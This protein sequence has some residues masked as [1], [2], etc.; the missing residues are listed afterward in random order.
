MAGI[1]RAALRDAIAYARGRTRTFLV[2]G[3][4]KPAEDPLV[5][6]VIG[7]LS[8][9]VFTLEGIVTGVS[10]VLDDAYA[11][12]ASGKPGE[13]AYLRADMA[14]YNGQ[15][16][17]IDLVL[18]ATSLLFEVGGA[19]AVSQTRQLD[20]HWRN[21][22]TL[23]SHNPAILRERLVGDYLLNGVNPRA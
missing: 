8:S 6:R 9:L 10:A 7:R 15:L 2:R 4:T 13:D 17:A 11:H 21:A 23:S 1:G 20:R 18:Q 16:M 5:Q 12:W 14:A 22:R 19:S 3:Q